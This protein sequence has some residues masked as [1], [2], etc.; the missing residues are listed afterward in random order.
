M[1]V[2]IV[3]TALFLGVVYSAYTS[4]NVLLEENRK[5]REFNSNTYNEEIKEFCSNKPKDGIRAQELAEYMFNCNIELYA[6]A[7]TC[8]AILYGEQFY[9][10]EC[11]S[12][13]FPDITV[14]DYYMDELHAFKNGKKL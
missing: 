6:N 14:T 9:S 3:A 7:N 11:I 5:I 1:R 2:A 10:T 4:Y 13:Q 12:K 8:M